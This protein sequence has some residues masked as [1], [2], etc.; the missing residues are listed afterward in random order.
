MT[1]P[2]W[3]SVGL[4]GV[5]AVMMAGAITWLVRSKLKDRRR[6]RAVAALARKFSKTR[7]VEPESRHHQERSD[8]TEPIELVTVSD[9]IARNLA[10][11]RA[12]RLNWEEDEPGAA[13]M[14]DWPTGVLPRVPRHD[15]EEW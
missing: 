14:S 13:D 4:L 12:V 10:E 1:G 7:P 15:D 6:A 5:L 11:G 9:L 3:V 8:D 2:A